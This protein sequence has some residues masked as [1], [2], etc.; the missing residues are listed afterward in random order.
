MNLRPFH[1]A[2][3]V[4]DLAEAKKFY[5]QV[6]QC[7]EGRSSAKWQDYDFYGSQLVAHYV[8]P[9]YRATDYFNPVDGDDVPVPHFGAVLDDQ[10]WETL[11]SRLQNMLDSNHP[12]LFDQFKFII[13]PRVRFKGQRGEQKTMFFKDPSGNN[14]EFKAMKN[15]DYLFEKV[16]SY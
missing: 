5:G 13:P 12:M 10:E 7:K 15:P 3:P 14:L 16:G 8:G 9:G 6:L 4:H 1:L 11:A 2:I